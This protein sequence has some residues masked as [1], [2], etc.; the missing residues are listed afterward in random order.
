MQRVVRAGRD[1][2]AGGQGDGRPGGVVEVM[3]GVVD[4][5]D[6]EGAVAVAAE[7]GQAAEV[8]GEV[9]VEGEEVGGRG[10][11]EDGGGA[12]SVGGFFWK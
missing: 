9:V 4:D 7:D 3:G 2:Q 11:V 12:V 8:V 1:E 5:V 10:E 6:G